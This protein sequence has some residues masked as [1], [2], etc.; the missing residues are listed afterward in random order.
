MVSYVTGQAGAAKKERAFLLTSY[1]DKEQK[2]VAG[3]YGA[4]W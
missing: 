2:K 1:G 3:V 4:H